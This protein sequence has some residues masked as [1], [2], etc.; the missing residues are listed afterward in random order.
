MPCT[1][2]HEMVPK[3]LTSSTCVQAARELMQSSPGTLQKVPME[4]RHLWDSHT[5]R[6]AAPTKFGPM[7]LSKP[8]MANGKKREFYEP[9]W[10]I[11]TS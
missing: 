2:F 11:W 9:Y 1:L 3:A 7:Q 5:V 8:A 10:Q 6:D 4:P